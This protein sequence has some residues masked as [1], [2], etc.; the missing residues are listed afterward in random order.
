MFSIPLSKG[1]LPRIITVSQSPSLPSRPPRSAMPDYPF[2]RSMTELYRNA[3]ASYFSA[4]SISPIRRDP[5]S[6]R[7]PRFL[8]VTSLLTARALE[9]TTTVW[10]RG[11]EE[12][13][14]YERF[15]ALFRAVFD[16]PPEGREGGEQL[17]QGAQTTAE[18]A[19]TFQNVAATS[20]CNELVLRSLFRSG[21]REEV[22]MELACRDDNIS[23]DAGVSMAIRLDDLLW[24]CLCPPRFSSPSF[25][26]AS[27]R[28]PSQP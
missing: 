21:L 1:L 27:R 16:Q 9:W 19:L 10:E 3:V 26:C 25:G 17:Q 5:T 22:Q 14:Y 11:E 28:T 23:L 7:G 2:R 8:S 6:S 12:L 4:P 15:M 20:R 18:C 13:G 24:E